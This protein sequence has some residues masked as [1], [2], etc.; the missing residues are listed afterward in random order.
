MPRLTLRYPVIS[1]FAVALLAL[2]A[3]VVGARPAAAATVQYQVGTTTT[4]YRDASLHSPPVATV[5]AGEV[6]FGS[7]PLLGAD[8]VVFVRATRLSGQDLGYCPAYGPG[9]TNSFT[10]VATGSPLVFGGT[11]VVAAAPLVTSRFFPVGGVV[12]HPA[13]F[14]LG[15]VVHHPTVFGL[16]GVVHPTVVRHHPTV[17]GLGGVPV[18]GATTAVGSVQFV[19]GTGAVTSSGCPASGCPQTVRQELTPL[20]L[21]RLGG[22]G[23]R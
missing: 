15:G 22:R 17:V 5:S 21:Q 6:I 13:V 7:D 23:V 8:A 20:P 16:G 9:F 10:A 19:V 11:S 1:V 18:L 3:L 12:H 2:G 14:G 4:C